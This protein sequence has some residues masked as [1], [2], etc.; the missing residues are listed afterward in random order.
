MPTRQWA[1]TTDGTY[2]FNSPVDWAFGFAPSAIDIAQFNSGAADT[3]TGDATVGELQFIQGSYS[4]A[5]SYLISGAQ[6]T[7]LSVASSGQPAPSALTILAGALVNGAQAVT[8]SGNTASLVIKGG[9]V[10]S[11]LSISGAAE[12][13]VYQGASF[14]ITGPISIASGGALV[15][16]ATV[17][18]PAVAINNAIQTSGSVFLGCYG[19][20]TD[21]NGVI[22]GPGLVS[23]TSGGQTATVA[24]NASNTFTGGVNF[25]A[26]GLTIAVGAANGL[27]TGTLTIS[28]GEL[29]AT[30]TETIANQ[31]AMSG[32]FTI[33]AAHGQTLTIGT[34]PFWTLNAN[35]TINFG[36]PG[37]DGVVVLD[38]GVTA[39]L[40]APFTATVQAGTLKAGDSL[41]VAALLN[42]DSATIVKTGATIDV[43][44]VS[45]SI[46]GLQGGGQV[47][48]SGAAAILTIKNPGA[49]SGTISGPLSVTLANGALTLS[50]TNTYSGTTYID[51]GATLILGSGGASGSVAG[52]IADSGALVISRGDTF[53]LNNVSGSGVLYQSGPGTTVLGTGLTYLGGT[54]IAAGTLSV[55]V[56]SALGAGALNLTGGELLGSATET[57]SGPT[58]VAFQGNSTVAAAH[59]QALTI[60]PAT[61]TF[62]SSSITIGAPG[63]DGVVA[64]QYGGAISVNSGAYTVTIQ[65]GTLKALDFVTTSVVGNDT[66]TTVQAGAT[67]DAAGQAVTISGLQGGGQVIDSG[68]AAALTLGGAG[69]FSGIISG[70]LS[71]TLVNGTTALSGANTYTGGTTINAG[72]TLV[73]GAGGA[74]GSVPGAITDNGSL[75]INRSDTVTLNNVSGT[76]RVVQSGPGATILGSG[77]SYSGG[78]VINAG[79]LS[80]AAPSALGSGA[81]TIAGGELLATTTGTITNQLQM[82]GAFTIAAAHGQTLTLSSGLPWALAGGS[83]ISFGAPG[84]DGVVVFDATSGSVQSNPFSLTVQAGTLK[85]GDAALSNLLHDATTSLVQSGATIDVA[86][87]AT[88]I[89][90]LQGGGLVTD[91]GA[92]ATL[93]INHGGSLS[94]TISG[95]LSVTIAGGAMTFSGANSYSGPTTIASGADLT[96]GNGGSIPGAV[97]DGGVLEFR[98]SGTLIENGVIS[99]GGEVVQDGS[100]VTVLT[101]TSSYTGGTFLDG[102]TLELQLPDSAGTGTIT[103]LSGGAAGL[104]IDG[105]AMPSN[106]ITGFSELDNIDLRGVSANGWSYSGGVLT[107][108]NGAATVGQLHLTTLF[109]NPDFGL[110]SDGAG[111]T[112]VHLEAPPR[113]FTGNGFSGLLFQNGDGTPALWLMNGATE[114]AGGAF[115]NPGASWRLVG[116]GD[117]NGDIK[118]DLV[119]QNSDGTPS[120]WLLNGTT[121]I[122]G[123][124]LPNPGAAWHL[125]ATGDFN[126]DGRSDLVWQN[127]DGTPAIWLMNGATEIAGG[128]LANPGASWRLVGTGD[129][130]GDGHG[131]LVW[132]NSDGTPAIWLMNG[133]T[134]IGGGNLPN[135]GASWRLVGT[136]DFNGD[137]HS[138]ILWQNSDGTPAIWLM[139]GLTEI[140]GGNLANPGPSWHLIGTGDFNGDGKSDLAWQNSDGT[141]AIWEM[142]GATEIFGGT[143]SNPGL[144]WHLI[145]GL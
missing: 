116:A 124:A 128:N 105:A 58:S 47:T 138:D 6:A 66:T 20:E 114:V 48:N 112:V 15:G 103:F 36:A 9:L 11:S 13:D 144:G 64:F 2:D 121:Q 51:A 24:L 137:G 43:A 56:P 81:L 68:G 82:N 42:D 38:V 74:S 45:T 102:G 72:A 35:A 22:S 18:G 67:I 86:G 19:G 98:L 88:S 3:I 85:A 8:V 41:G 34:A 139:N 5:G 70:P 143:V 79:T 49:F 97:V 77:L 120:I 125:F 21:F 100:G 12:V 50:T 52:A 92:A 1:V 54:V 10:A 94:G 80:V 129:F 32:N 123:A 87:L 140:A 76:G 33:A 91:S 75:A 16:R 119:W 127:T 106:Q 7:E 142:N 133:L 93:T 65:A 90:F 29:L 83:T 31:L 84:Q 104:Q 71:L 145:P 111:G 101:Q 26:P 113:D 89:S 40:G 14:D 117:F 55:G 110:A 135:P 62:E 4:L 23:L 107:L 99:G 73:L 118:S 69:S 134:Q 109:T 115:A 25:S 136:G 141:L 78:T 60:N 122:A 27:G 61:L 30:T 130:N 37:Q 63:Q 44:G 132:Q 126:G 28:G 96:I 131:D 53:T 39:S 17:G 57:I 59:G 46:N 108:L 95:A